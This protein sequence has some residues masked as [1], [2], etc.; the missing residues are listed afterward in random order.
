MHAL[1]GASPGAVRSCKGLLALVVAGGLRPL[2]AY[3]PAFVLFAFQD[4]SHCYLDRPANM[5]IVML[6]AGLAI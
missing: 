2:V 1:Q 4:T 6:L 5:T 3:I